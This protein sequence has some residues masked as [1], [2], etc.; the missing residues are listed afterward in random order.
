[1]AEG[2]IALGE[3]RAKGMTMLEVACRRCERH[4]RLKI[5]RLIAEHGTGVLD[6]CAIIAADCPRMQNRSTSI[7]ELCGV[8]FPELP[9]WF[10]GP[11]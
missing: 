10:L 9:R 6:V 3:M 2:V 1:M 4:G 11:Y 8:H 5:E 7:Y